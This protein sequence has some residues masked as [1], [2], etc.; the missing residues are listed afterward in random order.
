MHP[1]IRERL[2]R[3]AGS[4]ILTQYLPANHTATC[5][6]AR[7][8]EEDLSQSDRF[9][10]ASGCI[11][12][13]LEAIP[14]RRSG[15]LTRRAPPQVCLVERIA[16]FATDQIADVQLPL[17]V[18]AIQMSFV[19]HSIARTRDAGT[20]IVEL[21]TAAKSRKVDHCRRVSL[22]CVRVSMIELT[23]AMRLLLTFCVAVCVQR[24]TCAQPSFIETFKGHG[25]YSST[26]G[27]FQNLDNPDWGIAG[28]GIISAEGYEFENEAEFGEYSIDDL[29]RPLKELRTFRERITLRNVEFGEVPERSMDEIG[30]LSWR[31]VYDA[32]GNDQIYA[33]I[34]EDSEAP[35]GKWILRITSG[36][37][38]VESE[39]ERGTQISMEISYDMSLGEAQVFY[40]ADITD[41][42]PATSI[43]PIPAS[44]NHPSA[45]SYV[46][47]SFGASGSGRAN[48]VIERWT[49]FV[50]S[51]VVGDINGDGQLATAD[52]DLLSRAVRLG[53]QGE[54]TLDLNSDSRVD[55]LD[56]SEWV[57]ATGTYRGDG[58]LDGL[59]DSRDLVATFAAGQYEDASPHNSTWSTGDWNGDGEFGTSDL[60]LAFQD[61]GYEK[62][63][64]QAIV[65]PEPS[66]PTAILLTFAGFILSMLRS[67]GCGT[68]TL[69]RFVGRSCDAPVNSQP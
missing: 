19:C 69:S 34:Y 38:G 29:I 20:I 50:E 55:N 2:A 44:T 27:A 24:I 16:G 43:G 57:R 59:F 42:I 23:M 21:E 18:S 54:S 4:R 15:D 36:G 66:G 31:F 41:G 28:D 14:G 25:V 65:V 7:A 40:D 52:I 56:H 63:L 48:G 67:I 51:S 53:I 9:P 30:G 10:R 22:H 60:I 3:V 6:T 47:L 39:I 5:A 17:R 26:D 46:L 61:G 33:S 35:E 8:G 11:H 68:G 64:S 62:G 12:R 37:N 58:D 13:T 45:D 1:P 32:L 49:R